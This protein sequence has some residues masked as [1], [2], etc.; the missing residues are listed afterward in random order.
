MDQTNGQ[1]PAT[2]D[3]PVD[4]DPEGPVTMEKLS[5]QMRGLVKNQL[6]LMGMVRS[7]T[8][9]VTRLQH[10]KDPL[11]WQRRA[12]LTFAGACAGGGI[13]LLLLRTGAALAAAH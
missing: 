8:E 6:T 5:N 9:H 13:V 1:E 7:L 3:A 4:T 12:A 2:D 11:T 10:T